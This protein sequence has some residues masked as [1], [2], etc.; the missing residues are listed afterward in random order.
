[1]LDAESN[2]CIECGETIINKQNGNR[3]INEVE[4][5]QKGNSKSF[6]AKFTDEVGVFFASAFNTVVN[7][8]TSVGKNPFQKALTG[9][10]SKVQ[11]FTALNGKEKL[12]NFQE[13]IIINADDYSELI[14]KIFKENEAGKLELKDN[15]LKEK[16][17]L[18]KMKRLVVL[19][20]FAKKLMGIESVSR[21][22]INEIVAREKLADSNYRKFMT[23]DAFKYISE[24]DKGN[25]AILA[26]GEDYAKEILTQ[27]ADS[28]YI[29]IKAK[30]GRKSG[31]KFTSDNNDNPKLNKSTGSN[32]TGLEM[33]KQLIKDGYFST[34]RKLNDVVVYCE[35][36]KA[37]KYSPQNL[38]MALNRLVKD[39]YIE[40]EKNKDNQ[41]EYWKK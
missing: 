37:T 20:C 21:E 11:S 1:M 32:P 31:K 23:K 26:G 36:K 16:S 40:R 14:A 29:P 6:K 18:D 9:I 30:S 17:S 12:D 39:Q 4:Y 38:Q 8:T 19:F 5:D 28:E 27:I 13:A 3:A 34:K 33:C 41:Y 35:Q 2:Y 22:E 10:S 24:R 7:G 15:R 25:Y